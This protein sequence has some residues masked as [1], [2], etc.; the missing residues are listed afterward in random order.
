M[1][2]CNNLGINGRVIGVVST[3]EGGE[4]GVAIAVKALK[5]IW[6]NM[7]ASLFQDNDT[8]VYQANVTTSLHF[9]KKYLDN[10]ILQLSASEYE[11]RSISSSFEDY[12]ILPVCEEICT[13]LTDIC[14]RIIN[15]SVTMTNTNDLKVSTHN[16][17]LRVAIKGFEEYAKS[18]Q[19]SITRF[20]KVYGAV[21]EVKQPVVER[22]HIR[23]QLSNLIHLLQRVLATAEELSSTLSKK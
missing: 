22:E 12:I 4:K 6:L 15:F 17:E 7:P 21:L 23:E 19:N 18:V 11:I 9:F 13:H 5:E 16:I 10:F 3:R 2:A 1:V 8:P 14:V 20:C